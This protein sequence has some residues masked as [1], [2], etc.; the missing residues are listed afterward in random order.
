MDKLILKDKTSIDV[1]MQS[2]GA[3]TVELANIG[4]VQTLKD[5]LTPANISVVQTATAT[6]EIAGNYEDLILNDAWTIKWEAD[7][8]VVA[9]FGLREK[10]EIEKIKEMLAIHDGAITDLGDV[11]G[12]M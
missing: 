3:I 9:T 1:E 5:K 12:G 2:I 4:A 8:H 11:V 7:N 6:G 10:S